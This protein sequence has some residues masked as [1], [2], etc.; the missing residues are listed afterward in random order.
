MSRLGAF[1]AG[2]SK[3]VLCVRVR[4]SRRRRIIKG[5]RVTVVVL[6]AVRRAEGR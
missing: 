1:T 5:D 6:S 4:L 2:Q 3:D